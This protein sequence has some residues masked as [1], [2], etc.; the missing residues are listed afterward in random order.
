MVSIPRLTEREIQ[1]AAMSGCGLSEKE[2]AAR[3]SISPNTVRVHVENI[4]RRLGAKNK[5]HA[6][7]ILIAANII[8][9]KHE[10]GQVD[11]LQA[12]SPPDSQSK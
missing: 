5:T 8:C 4:K 12:T 3:I 2:I 7:A 10:V 9:L 6:V 1:I 11:V